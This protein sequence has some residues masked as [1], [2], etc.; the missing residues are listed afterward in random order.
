MK[1]L[2]LNIPDSLDPAVARW[3]LARSLYEKGE[4][5]LEQAAEIV[6]LTPT[7]FKI[8]MQKSF[9]REDE[10]I[11]QTVVATAKPMNRQYFDQLV[12]QLDIKESWEDLTSQIGK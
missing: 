1:T 8:K 4:L 6:G 9:N 11:K 12:D 3:E 10:R 2:T 5:T 7:Y